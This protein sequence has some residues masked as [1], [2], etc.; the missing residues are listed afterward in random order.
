MSIFQLLATK[1]I[2]TFSLTKSMGCLPPKYS[3]LLQIVVG[4][5]MSI[6]KLLAVKIQQ[7]LDA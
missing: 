2:A 5:H 4:N 7:L 6:F 1:N 3:N